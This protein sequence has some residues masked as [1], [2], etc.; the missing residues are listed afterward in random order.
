MRR[1]CVKW[2]HVHTALNFE[3][4]SNS[5]DWKSPTSNSYQQLS[6]TEHRAGCLQTRLCLCTSTLWA[7]GAAIQEQTQRALSPCLFGEGDSPNSFGRKST[8]IC[9]EEL[10]IQQRKN[11]GNPYHKGSKLA[12]D[13]QPIPQPWLQVGKH[14]LPWFVRQFFGP[15]AAFG[16]DCATAADHKR[17]RHPT[18]LEL[19]TQEETLLLRNEGSKKVACPWI[20]REVG[21]R[22]RCSVPDS[23]KW[24]GKHTYGQRHVLPLLFCFNLHILIKNS[25]A[26]CPQI[27]VWN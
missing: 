2:R 13:R 6:T 17:F 10:N 9:A 25:C 7:I 23:W 3:F 24:G 21:S 5:K 20:L 14:R 12:A 16:S 8:K 18:F 27:S 4:S 22:D 26:A 1:H 19:N 15:W 11:K